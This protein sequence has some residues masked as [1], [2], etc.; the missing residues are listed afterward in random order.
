MSIQ[1]LHNIIEECMAIVYSHRQLAA[2]HLAA[3]DS[4]TTLCAGGKGELTD[5][6]TSLDYR[7]G[8]KKYRVLGVPFHLLSH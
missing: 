7:K 4:F 8:G 3:V 5:I 2:F 1:A 6:K